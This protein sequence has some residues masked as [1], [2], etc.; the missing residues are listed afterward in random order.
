MSNGWRGSQS[1]QE[2]RGIN[3]CWTNERGPLAGSAKPVKG[4]DVG[5]RGAEGVKGG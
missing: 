3:A 1:R 2:G 4:R 5:E